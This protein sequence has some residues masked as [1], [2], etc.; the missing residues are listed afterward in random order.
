MPFPFLTVNTVGPTLMK[1]G[2]DEQRRR[3][4]PG[5]LSG[6]IVFAIDYTEPDAG[7]DLASLRTR[8]VRD[9]DEWI[10]NGTKV[11]ISGA[12]VNTFGGG[13][14]EVL[15]D[16]ITSQGLGAVAPRRTPVDTGGHRK[17]GD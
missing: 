7:T 1:F 8:A 10:V 4:L 11:F 17:G 6:D 5:I 9:G 14:N 16:M 12:T 13:V 15:R 2:T 3:L